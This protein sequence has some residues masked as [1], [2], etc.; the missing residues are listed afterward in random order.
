MPDKT[1]EPCNFNSVLIYSNFSTWSLTPYWTNAW[2]QS[3]NQVHISISYF[4]ELPCIQHVETLAWN[5]HILARHVA[6]HGITFPPCLKI[7]CSVFLLQCNLNLSS[8]RSWLHDLDVWSQSINPQLN[9]LM[10]TSSR[11]RFFNTKM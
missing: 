10:H 4:T 6:F 7:V 8:V 1:R 11:L 3:T 9:F 2:H 5:V